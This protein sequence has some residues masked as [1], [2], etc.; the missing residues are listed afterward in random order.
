MGPTGREAVGKNTGPLRRRQPIDGGTG[1]Q[2][3]NP[4][5]PGL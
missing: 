1:G 2:E 4:P 3:H 5:C